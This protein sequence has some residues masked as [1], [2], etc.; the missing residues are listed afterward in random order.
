MFKTSPLM[1]LNSS[2]IFMLVLGRSTS[3]QTLAD[4]AVATSGAHADPVLW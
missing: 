1:W 3:N 2:I 4:R